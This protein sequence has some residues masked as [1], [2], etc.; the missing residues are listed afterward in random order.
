VQSFDCRETKQAYP[1]AV[2]KRTDWIPAPAFAGGRL[3]AG[4]TGINAA[5]FAL[6][7]SAATLSGCA[8]LPQQETARAPAHDSTAPANKPPSGD[9]DSDFRSAIALMQAEDWHAAADRLEAISKAE[10]GL[11]TPWVNL[12][13]ARTKLGDSAGAETAFKKAIEANSRNAEAWNQLGVVYRRSG[14]L[15]EALFSYN[16]ALKRERGHSDAHWNLA[17]LHDR[18]L[19]DPAL[20]LAH[21]EQYQQLTQSDDAQLQQWIA[22]LREQLPKA[23]GMTAGVT[24]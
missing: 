1:D 10:P 15:D 14:R 20:A 12:G 5:V 3:C 21:Y 8:G 17:I 9:V 24:K 23:V 22:S 13:I 18:Y 7:F 16:E 4:T 6:L 11:S 19:P 2:G